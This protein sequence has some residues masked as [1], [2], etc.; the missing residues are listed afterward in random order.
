MS[1]DRRVS[2]AR[3]LTSIAREHFRRARRRILAR[4]IRRGARGGALIGAGLAAL[5][6]PRV[7]TSQ[8]GM[9]PALARTWAMFVFAAAIGIGALLAH[10]RSRP[11]ARLDAIWA[12]VSAGA[13]PARDPTVGLF[14]AARA[15]LRDST[16]CSGFETLV[17]AQFTA[18]P[19]PDPSSLARAIPTFHPGRA[20]VM[21]LLVLI[22]AFIGRELPAGVSSERARIE[23]GEPA[24]FSESS[25]PKL[26]VDRAVEI[27]ALRGE[28]ALREELARLLSGSAALSP[29]VDTLRTGGDHP[30]LPALSANDRERLAR[31]AARATALGAPREWAEALL[32]SASTDPNSAAPLVWD[33]AGKRLAAA[34][35]D[36]VRGA[37]IDGTA[38]VSIPEWSEGGSAAGALGTSTP[39]G[40]SGLSPPDLGSTEPIEWPEGLPIAEGDQRTDTPVHRRD[41]S[42]FDPSEGYLRHPDLEPRWFPVIDAYRR[43][44]PPR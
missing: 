9:D 27:A 38:S 24:R 33:D 23:G 6:S 10:F 26:A 17:L 11:A 44:E 18:L 7:L 4:Q 20:G 39:S 43:L 2:S 1:A 31:V 14:P 3:P 37:S 41:P 32:A 36:W 34:A 30:R 12:R 15:I 22:A 40:A 21:L 42:E 16:A 5:L 19:L 13:D 25:Q 8:F 35:S 29:L 28:I